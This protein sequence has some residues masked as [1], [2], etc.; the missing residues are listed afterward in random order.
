MRWRAWRGWAILAGWIVVDDILPV[1]IGRVALFPGYAALLA[2]QTRYVDDAV[3]VLAVVVALIFWPLAG[4]AASRDQDP[5]PRREF[6]AANGWKRTAVAFTVVVAIGSVWTVSQYMT[7]TA[8]PTRAYIANARAALAMQPAGTA[9]LNRQVP[10]TVMIGLFGSRADTSVVLGPLAR[11]GTHLDWISQPTGNIGGLKMFGDDGRLYY[12]AIRGVTG[13]SRTVFADCLSPRRP[14][15]VV[16]LPAQLGLGPFVRVL[17]IDYLASAGA[18]GATV[19][20]TYAGQVGQIAVAPNAHSAYLSAT[21]SSAR[22]TLEAT[23]A[24]GTFCF[25]KAVAGYFIP[26]PGTGVPGPA[27]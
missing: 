22:V 15:L 1:M 26:L 16:P 10:S 20:V 12:A 23:L 4:P 8:A 24:A 19:T 2:T 13:Q 14:R 5:A 25:Q 21:G 6:F 27:Q 7:R 9:I 11:S 17:R 18:A 3:A